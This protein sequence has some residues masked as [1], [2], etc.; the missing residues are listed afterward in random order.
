MMRVLEK[1]LESAQKHAWVEV[2]P[3]AAEAIA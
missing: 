3:V 1:V 2:E